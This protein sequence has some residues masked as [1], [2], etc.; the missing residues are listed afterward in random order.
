MKEYEVLSDEYEVTEEMI[1]GYARTEPTRFYDCISAESRSK[2]K[3][4]ALKR[5]GFSDFRDAPR[6]SVRLLTDEDRWKYSE[7]ESL[8]SALS[9]EQANSW[10]LERELA[11]HRSEHLRLR[12]A[13]D[14][15][16]PSAFLRRLL[17]LSEL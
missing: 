14:K 2:A 8:S 4:I 13:V 16:I 9:E 17:G 10:K 5:M 3:Y 7:I 6:L 15:L 1:D 12:G 11:Y